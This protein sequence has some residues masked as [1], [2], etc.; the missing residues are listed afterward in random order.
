[1]SPSCFVDYVLP[2]NGTVVL[3][4]LTTLVAA[5]TEISSQLSPDLVFDWGDV[6][7]E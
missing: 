1:M 3:E 6:F 4:T 2:P 5:T 7:P